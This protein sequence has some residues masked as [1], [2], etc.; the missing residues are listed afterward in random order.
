[1]VAKKKMQK[2][3]RNSLIFYCLL[4]A[5]PVLQFCVFYIGVNFNSILLAF[6]KI[7]ASNYSSFTWTLN[8]FKQ[9]FTNQSNFE[10]LKSSLGVSFKAY[11]ISLLIGVPLGLF[12]SYYIYKKMPLSDFFRVM[13][14]LPSIISS[15]ILVTIYMYFLDNALYP[16]W[17]N[18]FKTNW[19]A[20]KPPLLG[21]AAKNQFATVM[22]YNVLVS[23]GTSVLMYSNKMSSIPPEIVESAHLDGAGGL[24]EF[25]YIVL[26][27]VFSTLS[28]FLVTGVSGIFINQIN[29]FAFFGYGTPL[30]S[31][32][33]GFYMYNRTRDAATNGYI[34]VF[35]PYAALGLMI[36]CFA[37]PATFLVKH[38]L[39]KYGPSED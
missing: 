18:I 2:N 15:I 27:Q 12:F 3:N 17:D 28:V 7:D 36:T 29:G 10:I 16:L 34:D 23:F 38:L 30:N 20:T 6:K 9:W 33:I 11:A 19:V 8:N 26:P 13:L 5:W 24:K 22:F 39:T 21:P 25:W 35:P 32:T 4:M 37:I 14:F 1:M 31:T